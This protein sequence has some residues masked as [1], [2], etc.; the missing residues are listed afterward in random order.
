MSKINKKLE[1]KDEVFVVLVSAE[2]NCSIYL[3][4]ILKEIQDEDIN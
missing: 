2:K 1:K 3:N 4:T